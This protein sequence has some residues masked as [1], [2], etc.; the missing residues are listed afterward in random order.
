M[1][2]MNAKNNLLDFSELD[3]RFEQGNTLEKVQIC[4]LLLFLLAYLYVKAA[5]MRITGKLE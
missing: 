5:W 4:F 3:H 2:N 1:K